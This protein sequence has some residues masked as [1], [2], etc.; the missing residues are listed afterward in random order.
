MN[1]K[2]S[3]VREPR[4]KTEKEEIHNFQLKDSKRWSENGEK[5]GENPIVS[6]RKSSTTVITIMKGGKTAYILVDDLEIEEIQ[7]RIEIA[8]NGSMREKFGSYI[9]F[10]HG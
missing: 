10:K 5:N 2:I 4:K 6:K 7:T 1:T 9:F 3:R 8:T